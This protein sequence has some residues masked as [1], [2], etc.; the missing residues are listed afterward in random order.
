MELWT[1]YEKYMLSFWWAMKPWKT[2]STDPN[3]VVWL[4]KMR[5]K[6]KKANL[7][8]LI[9]ANS[10]VILLKIG[11]KLSIFRSMLPSNLMDDLEKQKKIGHLFCTTSSFVHHFK[12]IGEFKLQLQSRMLNLGKNW[13]FVLCDLEIWWMTLTNNMAPFLYY[14][15]LCKSFQGHRRILKLELQSGNAQFRSK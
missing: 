2:L 6:L 11:F 3:N 15:K 13:R 4:V 9:A 1:L 5:W 12:P 10:L 8:D 7:R 14:F